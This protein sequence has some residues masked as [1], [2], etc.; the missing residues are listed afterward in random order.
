MEVITVKE[1]LTQM[2][3][4]KPFSCKCITFDRK[5][6]TGGEVLDILEA[7]LLTNDAP[8]TPSDRAPTPLEAHIANIATAPKKPNHEKF[9]TRNVRLCSA[10]HPTETIKK[11][12]P[13][14]FIEFNGMTVVP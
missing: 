11:I 14:L 12:H 3:T 6:R 7:V 10:G 2:E 8:L 1:C 5:R 4:G 13:P 9:Y